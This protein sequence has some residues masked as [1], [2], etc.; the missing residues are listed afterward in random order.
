VPG[1]D[2]F[3]ILAQHPSIVILLT[4]GIEFPIF[5]VQTKTKYSPEKEDTHEKT[6]F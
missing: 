1:I 4:I 2:I 3:V 6:Q 5:S